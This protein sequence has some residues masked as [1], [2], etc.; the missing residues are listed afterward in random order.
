MIFKQIRFELRT[1]LRSLEKIMKRS[2][3]KQPN[4]MIGAGIV[5]SEL[6]LIASDRR[7]PNYTNNDRLSLSLSWM[8]QGEKLGIQRAGLVPRKFC[9]IFQILRHIESLDT[10]MKH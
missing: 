10:C 8:E 4:Q 6:Q 2:F 9:K 3:V 1:R 7:G 5:A